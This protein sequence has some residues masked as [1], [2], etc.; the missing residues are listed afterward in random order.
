MVASK[1]NKKHPHIALLMGKTPFPKIGFPEGSAQIRVKTA[2]LSNI[3]RIDILEKVAAPIADKQLL[4]ALGYLRKSGKRYKRGGHQISKRRAVKKRSS[5]SGLRHLPRTPFG[6]AP[7]PRKSFAHALRRLVGGNTFRGKRTATDS[8]AKARLM[9]EYPHMSNSM[10]PGLPFFGGVRDKAILAAGR[11]R[12]ARIAEEIAARPKPRPP[13][14]APKQH[15]P[16]ERD[17]R[18]FS[19]TPALEQ[20]QVKDGWNVG[21]WRGGFRHHR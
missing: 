8:Y 10:A 4:H 15:K 17:Y 19:R 14:R 1:D 11:K 6:G 2:S 3:D 16:S 7:V 13:G 18:G 9:A 21:A 12:T 20:L 5:E